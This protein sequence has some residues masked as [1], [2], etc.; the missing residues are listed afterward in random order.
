MTVGGILVAINGFQV[1]IGLVATVAAFLVAAIWGYDAV[2]SAKPLI[3][4]GLV[5]K[6]QTKEADAEG[7]APAEPPEQIEAQ[8]QQ[9]PQAGTEQTN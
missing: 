1:N 5:L 6:P 4:A 7:A 3:Q 8:P 2:A 9:V